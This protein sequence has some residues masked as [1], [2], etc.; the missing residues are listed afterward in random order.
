MSE[1]LPPN[2]MR[3]Y[4]SYNNMPTTIPGTL[5]TVQMRS[6]GS[7]IPQYQ[8]IDVISTTVAY[9]LQ[10]FTDKVSVTSVNFADVTPGSSN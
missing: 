5:V 3:L 7:D 2:I 1:T 10:V 9:V 4:H 8:K 6:L